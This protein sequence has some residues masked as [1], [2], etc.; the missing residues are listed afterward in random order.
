MIFAVISVISVVISVNR[1][2]ASGL[3]PHKTGACIIEVYLHVKSIW[4]K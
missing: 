2:T 1:L 3:W 4:G